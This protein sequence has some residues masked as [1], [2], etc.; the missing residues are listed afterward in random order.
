[1]TMKRNVFLLAFCQ[2]MMM[3]GNSL[4]IATASLVGYL[5][6]EDKSLAT[7]PLALQFLATMLTAVPASFAMQ[8]LGRRS[9][10][11]IG[12]ALGGA[13]AAA[14]VAAIL[15]QD[16]RLFCAA[17]ALVGMFNGF[18][19]YY[20]FAAV[21]VATGQYKPKAISYVMAGGVVAAFAGPN[22]AN[23]TNG[24]LGTPAFAG[25]YA[26]LLG[27]YA[28]SLA[29]LARLEIPKP[30]PATGREPGRPL[31]AILRQPAFV[32]AVLAGM[33][34]Y[35]IM[36]L[37]MTA[38]PLAMKGHAHTF[39]DTA[40]V[41][42][43]HV[44]GMFAPSFFTGALI[45]RFGVL[46]VLIAGALLTLGCVGVNFLGTD[47]WH[48]WLALFLLGVGWNFL[49]VGAT[50]LL[51]E[52]YAESEK[53][54]AQAFNDFMVFTTVTVS[55][56]SAG[57]LQYNYGWQ[58]VNAGVLPSILLILAAVTWLK[59]RQARAIAAG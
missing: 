28:L 57:M 50:D 3:T 44:F 32:V 4:I 13:G 7:I 10:F 46:N 1:M 34:G 30:A 8:R 24:W 29:A 54:K 12:V 55:S 38:T 19:I 33:L 42:Q 14:A 53:A 9:G 59:A 31:G 48:F 47:V 52:T 37:V 56:L 11:L 35:G 2:A 27:I 16:F 36:V 17:T 58:T 5:L 51:T 39:G 15:A 26:A 6:A 20:R 41:I 22:L 45:Q 25:S 18:G 49:F 43:W 40:F 23:W 21:D